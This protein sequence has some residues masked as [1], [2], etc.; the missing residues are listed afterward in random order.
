MTPVE[1]LRRM[2]QEDMTEL[3]D[4]INT[5]KASDR[6]IWVHLQSILKVISR[7][8]NETILSEKKISEY[9]ELLLDLRYNIE[10]YIS[11]EDQEDDIDN[12]IIEKLYTYEAIALSQEMYE[13]CENVR[14]FRLNK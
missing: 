14:R 9:K 10:E 1:Q 7:L 4:F 13:I 3:P 2:I 8:T 6:N 11:D 12:F 5:L